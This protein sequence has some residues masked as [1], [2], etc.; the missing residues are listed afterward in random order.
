MTTAIEDQIER[1]APGFR[2]CIVARHA[3]GPPSSN[4]ATPIW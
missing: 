3:M 1:F 4:A 2:D